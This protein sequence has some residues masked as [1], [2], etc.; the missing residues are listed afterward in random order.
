MRKA[1]PLL[2]ATLDISWSQPDPRAA[3]AVVE[4]H[5]MGFS[6]SFRWHECRGPH[7]YH[8]FADGRRASG[9]AARTASRAAAGAAAGSIEGGRTNGFEGALA[10]AHLIEHIAIDFVCRVTGLRRCSG[11]TAALRFPIGR[12]HLFLECPDRL[13]GRLALALAVVTL[14]SGLAGRPPADDERDML[15]AARAVFAQPGRPHTS[16]AV[17]RALG[18]SEG[19]AERA[20]EAL[21]DLGYLASRPWTVN[22]SGCPEYRLAIV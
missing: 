5:L 7:S 12:Y 14:L 18:W 3:L 2:R 15:R 10:L 17:A 16:P 4:D 19:R 9:A 21:R 6:R 8:V 13:S 11:V 22:T 20:L 1:G